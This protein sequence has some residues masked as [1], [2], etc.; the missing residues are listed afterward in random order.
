MWLSVGNRF[1]DVFGWQTLFPKTSLP[2]FDQ[3]TEFYKG[4][5]YIDGSYGLY[6][7]Q[8]W[9]NEGR[10]LE[11]FS[12][13]MWNLKKKKNTKRKELWF[14][15][16]LWR[17][18]QW[19]EFRLWLGK[20]GAGASREIWMRRTCGSQLIQIVFI[21]KSDPCT[22]TVV[23]LYWW[24]IPSRTSQRCLKPWRAPNPTYITYFFLCIH[25]YNK[26]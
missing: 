18:G 10:G 12:G 14:H 16:I 8:C 9:E 5:K 22:S 4:I 11:C 1:N 17:F 20:M 23:P 24:R 3:I 15:Q 25:T 19:G 6:S 13:W 7:K 26:V 2:L 21:S